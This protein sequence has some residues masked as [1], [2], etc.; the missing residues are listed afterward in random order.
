[1]DVQRLKALRKEKNL[2]QKQLGEFL[3]LSASAVSMYEQGRRNPDHELF[4]AMCNFFGVSTDYLINDSLPTEVE[5]IMSSVKNM[6]MNQNA[7][8]FSGKPLNDDDI[9]LIL[10]AVQTGVDFALKNKEKKNE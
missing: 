4:K 3:G 7:L 9:K 2:S 6:L 10:S 1:M 5:Q 8:M